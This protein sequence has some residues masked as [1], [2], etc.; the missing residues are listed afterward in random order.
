MA[1]R[2]REARAGPETASQR[3]REAAPLPPHPYRSSALFHGIL[4]GLIVLI[5][6]LVGSSVTTAVV[7]A[8]AYFVLATGWSWF[9]FSQRI[10]ARTQA[11]ADAAAAAAPGGRS[12]PTKSG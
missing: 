11:E 10:R 3:R 7:V 2:P 9:R 8:V 12:K 4:A 1:R 5:A 6:A